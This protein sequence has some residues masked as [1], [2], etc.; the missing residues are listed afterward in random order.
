MKIWN[1]WH[2]IKRV[3]F[4]PH[5]YVN[6]SVTDV[7]IISNKLFKLFWKIKFGDLFWFDL[8]YEF[9]VNATSV[10]LISLIHSEYI[11][12]HSK[13]EN[14]SKIFTQEVV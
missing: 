12:G 10:A 11:A 9:F 4:Y 14:G 3:I 7:K 13:M 1:P 2:V 6:V 5:A 8:I